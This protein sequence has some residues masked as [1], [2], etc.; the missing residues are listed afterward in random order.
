MS[1]L[2]HW[3]RNSGLEDRKDFQEDASSYSNYITRDG[4]GIFP[5]G[6]GMGVGGDEERG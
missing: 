3:P 6:C 4:V 5:V 2:S 1:L